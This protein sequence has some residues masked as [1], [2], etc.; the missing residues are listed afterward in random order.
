MENDSL[1]AR[2]N[3]AC[4]TK[5]KVVVAL[6]VFCIC[7]IACVS[8]GKGPN[9]SK[10]FDITQCNRVWTERDQ[11]GELK[12]FRTALINGAC[13]KEELPLSHFERTSEKW[14]RSR[15]RCTPQSEIKSQIWVSRGNYYAYRDGRILV[16]LDSNTGIYRRIRI[17]EGKAGG[18]ARDQ[19]AI[20]NVLN[21]NQPVFNREQGCF[22]IRN[23][24]DEDAVFGTQIL[25][26]TAGGIQSEYF[27]PSEVYKL[28]RTGPSS[29]LATRFD[30]TE[31]W[32]FRFCPDS[33]TPVGF[34][35]FV[36]NGNL[37][38]FP[39][40]TMGSLGVVE[41]TR[42]E[43]ILIR[44]EHRFEVST[45]VDFEYAWSN[46]WQFGLEAIISDWVFGVDFLVDTPRYVDQAWFDFIRGVR[47]RMP[48][49][50]TP[51]IPP[52]CYRGLGEVGTN[53][54]NVWVKGEVCY[55]NGHYQ[56]N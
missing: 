28:D 22:Y 55:E 35:N 23:A 29:I 30:A 10:K 47:P 37:M 17:A 33:D 6:N 45:N 21:P 11:S 16:S 4:L 51:E 13:Y 31:D 1:V 56:F 52:L 25:F 43:A 54:G 27:A 18:I 39:N 40:L 5:V 8:T 48:D 12:R 36:R 20:V 38:F 32:D 46:P 24:V 7:S 53:N 34:C 2:A 15:K 41:A 42:I 9:K 3:M 50:K 14:V 49:V 44:Q 26:D 19:N